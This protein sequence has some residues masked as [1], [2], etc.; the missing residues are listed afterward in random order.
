MVQ[1]RKFLASVATTGIITVAG[2]SSGGGDPTGSTE[3][4]NTSN[5]NTNTEEDSGE[6]QFELVEWNIPSE[7]EINEPTNI[8]VTVENAGDSAGEYIAPI[9]ERTPNSEWTRLGEAEFGTIQP[10]E[11][12][13]MTGDDFVYRYINRYE[14]RLDDFQQTAVLQT[15]SAKIDWGTEY[16]TP[17]G[18]VIRVDEPNLQGSY[19]YENYN[20]EVSPKEPDSGGQWAFVNA[21]VRNETGQSNFSPLATDISLLY[22]SSQADGETVLLDEPINKGEPFEGGEL[23]PGVERSGW[24]AYQIP[25]GV[26]IDDLT[27]AW[28]KT[29]FEGEIAVNWE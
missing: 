1:R 29:T 7:I 19:E 5:E 22:G 9:Y 25:S 28:S 13:E 12:A 24:I 4:E 27:V 8:S 14:Y 2:C 15:V 10:G 11:R 17:N 21:Y 3:S 20:G 26:S 18:Y 23:Q 16:T 6:A